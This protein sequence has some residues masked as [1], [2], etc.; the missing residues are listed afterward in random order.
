MFLTADLLVWQARENGLAL[1]TLS[2]STT[3]NVVANGQVKNID[4]EWDV[5]FRVGVGYNMPHDGWDLSLTWLRFYT[6]GHRSSH[7]N[8][9]ETIYPRL[10][11]PGDIAADNNTCQKLH[12]HWHL[13]LNQLDLD[14]GREFFVSKWLT[15][16]PHIGLRTDWIWQKLRVDYDNFVQFHKDVEVKDKDDWWGIGV[17]GGVDTQW[18]LGGGWSIYGNFDAA[19]LYGFHQASFD[20]QNGF[21][22]Q[23]FVDTKNSYHISHPVLDLQL[24]LRWDY[25]FSHD[26]FH[27]GLQAG[28]EHHVYFNQNQFMYFVDDYNNGVFVSNQ[29]D[30]TFQGWTFGARFDF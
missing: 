8:S 3:E 27:L 25:M 13:H 21:S 26:R 10:A 5:G 30:L 6:D 28:W 29:G 12:G 19:I 1:G 9:D 20:D 18:G 23:K 7:A 22:T 14:L 17:Q 15:F 16:R 24:G 11:H 4:F 2:H